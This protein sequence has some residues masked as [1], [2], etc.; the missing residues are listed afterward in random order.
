MAEVPRF[1]S[2]SQTSSDFG[3]AALSALNRSGRTQLRLR[4]ASNQTSTRYL[5]IGSGCA[6]HA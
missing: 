3:A 2:G 6:G 5:W 1:T 4:F